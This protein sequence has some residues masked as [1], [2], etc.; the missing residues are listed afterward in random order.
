[1]FGVFLFITMT[2]QM[3]MQIIPMFVLQRT[4]YEAREQPS[5]TYCWQSFLLANISVELV[6]NSVRI[7]P[8]DRSRSLTLLLITYIGAE[9]RLLFQLVLSNWP[10]AQC[11]AD[12]RSRFKR[13]TSVS[14]HLGNSVICEL[15]CISIDCRI[16]Q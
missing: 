1:M 14:L 15:T 9:C 3:I 4:L 13:N 12:R 16:G 7:L 10:V 11:R 6:W 5:K 8:Y 2:V